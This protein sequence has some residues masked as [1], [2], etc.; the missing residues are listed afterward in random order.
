MARFEREVANRKLACRLKTWNLATS[1]QRHVLVGIRRPDVI[2]SWSY[3]PIVFQLLDH[4]GRPSADARHSKHGRK[5]VNVN[6]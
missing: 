4:V 6:A 5:Q 3:Q 2:G 1:L